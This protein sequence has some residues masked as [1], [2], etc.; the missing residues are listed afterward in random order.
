M[1][2]IGNS[3][4]YYNNGIDRLLRPMAEER[5]PDRT[6][7][8]DSLTR[9]S[10]TFR[11]HYRHA[12]TDRRLDAREW[13]YVI[14]QAA[15]FEPARERSRPDFLDYGGRLIEAVRER[16]AEPVLFQTWAW[17]SDPAMHAGLAGGYELL[18]GRHGVRVAPV[19]EAWEAVRQRGPV[20]FL[21]ADNRHP[22]RYGSYL[23]ACVFFAVL[24][25][26]SPEGLAFDAG[27]PHE[28]ADF[29]QRVA[30]EAVQRAEGQPAVNRAQVRTK[31]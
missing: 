26:E 12:A 30:W 17:Q 13:H 23:A 31:R 19:G 28:A 1:L 18:G 27:L 10:E 25:G 8:I 7:E 11:G 5:F 2:F 3:F 14:L 21:H 16:G 4:T 15:S 29:L 6:F 24:F 9:P 22:S 20:D